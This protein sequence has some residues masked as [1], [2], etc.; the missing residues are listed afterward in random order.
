MKKLLFLLPAVMTLISTLDAALPPLYQT[1]NEINAILKSPEFGKK[2]HSGEV[3]ETIQKNE[4]GYL[5]TTNYHT[6]QI[7]IL[8]QE[9]G[10]IGPAQFNLQFEE[11]Q[12]LK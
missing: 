6:L 3:I 5:V 2:L 12:P 11:P 1:S 4:A 7:D 10:K 8:Y 9:N